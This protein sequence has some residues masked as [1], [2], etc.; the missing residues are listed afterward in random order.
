MEAY[1]QKV[2]DPVLDGYEQK[3]GTAEIAH[4]FKVS[5]S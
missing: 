3:L 4:R 1:Q 2:R 5:R